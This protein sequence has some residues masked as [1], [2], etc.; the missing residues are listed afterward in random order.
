MYEIIFLY[1]LLFSFTY[2]KVCILFL[3]YLIIHYVLYYSFTGSKRFEENIAMHELSYKSQLFS[4][5][6][7]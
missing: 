7:S 4:V 5:Y 1:S 6:V 3:D 2:L